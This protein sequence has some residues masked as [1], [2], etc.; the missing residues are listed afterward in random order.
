MKKLYV[1]NESPKR[2]AGKRPRS[3]D[4]IRLELK[5]DAD[6]LTKFKTLV[7]KNTDYFYEYVTA[8]VG[9]T[10]HTEEELTD[11]LK[12]LYERSKDREQEL[13]SEHSVN[14]QRSWQGIYSLN[15]RLQAVLF[16]I[17][18]DFRMLDNKKPKP[19][20]F[21]TPKKRTREQQFDSAGRKARRTCP[22]LILVAIDLCKSFCESNLDTHYSHFTNT[23]D[24]VRRM[25]RSETMAYIRLTEI[26][27]CL[28]EL[29]FTSRQRTNMMNRNQCVNYVTLN[30][31]RLQGE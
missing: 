4:A 17:V 27:E 11:E 14:K 6:L 8:K 1:I 3:I 23:V 24:A 21:E 2:S 28:I 26:H 13:M 30:I 9:K 15:N 12:R 29:K 18:E 10:D 22:E 31:S 16:E 19:K 5:R 20:I 25:S 7:I